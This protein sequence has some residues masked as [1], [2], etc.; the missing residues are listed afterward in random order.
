M[1]KRSL[2]SVKGVGFLKG[3]GKLLQQKLEQL[4]MFLQSRMAQLS[5]VWQKRVLLTYCICAVGVSVFVSYYSLSG[6]STYSVAITPIIPAPVPPA[7]KSPLVSKEVY[8]RIHRLR[9]HL[10]SV[11]SSA[12]HNMVPLSSSGDWTLRDT[13]IYLEQVYLQ[14][15]K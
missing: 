12:G 2:V 6:K 14:Q 8:E 10:D 11:Q 15:F 1:E 3:F 7:F 5:L 4:A 9:I 13:L